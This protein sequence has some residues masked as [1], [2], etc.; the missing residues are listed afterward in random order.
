MVIPEALKVNA[1]FTVTAPVYVCVPEVV[2]VEVLIAV[3]P[4]T[5]KFLPVPLKVTV[6]VVPSPNTA[7]PVIANP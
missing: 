5:D 2:I 1:V 7:L 6:S 3:V 4:D